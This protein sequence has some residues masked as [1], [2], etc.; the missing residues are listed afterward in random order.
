[1]KTEIIGYFEMS[2]YIWW[3]EETHVLKAHNSKSEM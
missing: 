2:G 3:S 1:M